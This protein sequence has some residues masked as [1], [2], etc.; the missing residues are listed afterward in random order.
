MT[1]INPE[2]DLMQPDPL[3]EVHSEV[4]SVSDGGIDR[5]IASYPTGTYLCVSHGNDL[6]PVVVT[7]WPWILYF[8]KKKGNIWLS[9]ETPFTCSTQDIV[10]DLPAPDIQ[11]LGRSMGY[12][13]RG[14]GGRCFTDRPCR[15]PLECTNGVVC[16][17]PDALNNYFDRG[18]QICKPKDFVD[19]AKGKPTSMSKPPSRRK[20]N[21]K[22]FHANNGLYTETSSSCAEPEHDTGYGQDWWKVNLQAYYE[23]HRLFLLSIGKYNFIRDINQ[24]DFTKGIKIT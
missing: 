1:E 20:P 19:I 23:V 5:Q 8:K 22:S 12:I 15:P 2:V 4:K 14:F 21:A 24:L 3:T 11:M 17:C 9:N 7:D 16:I 6:F 13:F 10:Q 18:E